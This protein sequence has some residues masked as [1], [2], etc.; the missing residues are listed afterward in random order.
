ML[1]IGS[2]MRGMMPTTADPAFIERA[3]EIAQQPDQNPTVRATLLTGSDTL[4]RVLRA[5]G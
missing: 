4:S 2:L 5:R 3:R 1:A